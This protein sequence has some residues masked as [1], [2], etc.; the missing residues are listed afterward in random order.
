MQTELVAITQALLYSSTHGVEP[1][2]I[3]TDS[4][5]A[6][7]ALQQATVGE[8]KALMMHLKHLL[9]MHKH[10]NR[11]V[12]LNW[13]PSHIGI[14]GND[15]TDDLAKTTKLI[16]R[17]QIT[18]QPS[19]Q[20]IKNMLKEPTHR[21]MIQ[22]VHYWVENYSYSARWYRVTSN[23]EPPPISKQTPRKLAVTIHRLRLGY[24]ANWEMLDGIIRP[25][26]HCQN[27]TYHPLLHYLLECQHTSR[28]QL[29]IN[30]PSDM[31]SAESIELAAKL[32]DVAIS[33]HQDILLSLPPPR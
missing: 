4:K 17:V 10:Q 1:V 9:L 14:P 20:Q 29:H 3:H 16:D 28:L 2:P 30:V 33:R 23:L 11:R 21:K 18:V 5:S 19:L 26:K 6:L 7:R 32:V 31:T 15:K 27:D 8:N 24:K 12:T 13:M 25:C 22:D